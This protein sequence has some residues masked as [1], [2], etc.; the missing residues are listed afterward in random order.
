[1]GWRGRRDDEG[2]ATARPGLPVAD[3]R[4]GAKGT[5][6]PRGEMT[7]FLGG[8]QGQALSPT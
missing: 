6:D 8:T 3:P 7:R 1:M 5:F 4:R 2:N